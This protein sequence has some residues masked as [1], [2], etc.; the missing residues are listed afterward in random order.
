MEGEAAKNYEVPR[1]TLIDKIAGRWK[2]GKS[3]G[4]DPY[5]SENEEN[6]IVR[7][8]YKVI[9]K[10]VLTFSINVPLTVAIVK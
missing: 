9:C 10:I 7:Y 1:T 4:R 8:V 2:D 5:L 6:S 3:I